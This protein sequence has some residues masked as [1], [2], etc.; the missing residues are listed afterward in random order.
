MKFTY[1]ART[2]EGESK[3]GVI[4]ASSREAALEILRQYGL[5]PT[6]LSPHNKSLKEMLPSV[7]RDVSRQD[8]ILFTRQLSIMVRSEIPVVETLETIAKQV[9]KE[10]FKERILKMAQFVE[11]GRPLSEAMENFPDMFSDFYIGMIR[12]GEQAGEVPQSLDY[13]ADYLEKNQKLKGQLVGA[14]LYPIFVSLFF[15]LLIFVMS[16]FVIPNFKTVFEDM[17]IEL[18]LITQIVIK[19]SEVLRSWWWVFLVLFFG[20]A[21][22]IFYFF[23]NEETKKKADQFLLEVPLIS[24]LLKKVYLSR[25]ALNLSTLISS[26]VPISDALEVTADLVGNHAYKEIILE[27][28][29]EVRS[30][31]EISSVF[32][33]YP[34]KFSVFFNQ[35]MVTGERAGK[36]ESTLGNI[37]TF[38]EKEVDQTLERFLKFI[39]PALIIVLGVLVGGLALS[40]FI[41]LFQQ[42]G[43]AM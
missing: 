28:R 26:G 14:L 25:I 34:D 22:L 30:G 8:V 9:D 42:G 23:E 37:V 38:Y 35:M 17:E 19:A 39:E 16:I 18:P 13:L 32:K 10:I 41:P 33:S 2:E 6:S 5:Y 1:Q 12:A 11:D 29:K 20:A 24:G 15:V 3:K 27:A 31:S 40:L 43:L 36:M 4:E 7:F 21:S